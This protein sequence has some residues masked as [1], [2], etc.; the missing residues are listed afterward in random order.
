M[1][2]AEYVDV[3]ENHFKYKAPQREYYPSSRH[4][5][6]GDELEGWSSCGFMVK[7]GTRMAVLK[8]ML[9]FIYLWF[10]INKI[11]SVIKL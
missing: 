11:Y 5:V 9:S 1:F 8:Y 6:G 4:S 2:F 3:Y 10:R 7:K